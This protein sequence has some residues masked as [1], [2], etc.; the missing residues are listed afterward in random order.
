M[1]LLESSVLR[2]IAQ[3][4]KEGFKPS[5][6]Q[7]TEFEARFNGG[8][9]IFQVVGGRA[10]IHINGVLTNTPSFMASLFGGGNT[11]Y[12][13]I[14]A[15]VGE[16]ES[17]TEVKGIDL[18]VGASPGGHIT[19]MFDAVA[20]LQG[21]KKPI[22]AYVSDLAASATYALVS[23]AGRVRAKNRATQFGSLGVAISTYVDPSEIEISSTLAPKKRPDLTT[24]EGKAVIRELLDP[25][26]A[27]L[28]D[29][30]AT[31]RKTTIDNVNAEF[32]QGAVLLADE[33]LSRG[34][35]DAIDKPVLQVVK[36][37]TH[38]T[39]DL[40]GKN[41]EA[42]KM[43]YNEFKAQHRNHYEAAVAEGEAKERDRVTAHLTL[44]AASGAMDIATGAIKDGS[45]LTASLQASYM[46]QGMNNKDIKD[47]T[48]DDIEG[49]GADGQDTGGG[50]TD[51]ESDKVLSAIEKNLGVTKGV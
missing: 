32:G 19:G 44:G 47:R 9:S 34:M 37:A 18:V 26:H 51:A 49:S 3:A 33:A 5:A 16:A 1:W 17:R 39:A 12:P 6:E 31:G 25:M 42:M 22:D 2:M 45:T 4:E 27:L 15:A 11:T 46:A 40:S 30:V 41:L 35:I 38:N 8:D 29:A 24:P 7:Q 48:A 28:A 43:D 14:I 10:Q 23:Q 36:T 50:D 21:A 13:S 20:A